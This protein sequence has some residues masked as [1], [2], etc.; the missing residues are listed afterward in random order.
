[1]KREIR[2]SSTRKELNLH[3]SSH[4]YT[5][6]W[7]CPSVRP[8]WRTRVCQCPSSTSRISPFYACPVML[9][10]GRSTWGVLWTL[11]G[12][13]T[14]KHSVKEQQ[15]Y[16]YLCASGRFCLCRS[17]QKEQIVPWVWPKWRGY[18]HCLCPFPS[19]SALGTTWVLGLGGCAAY[20][21]P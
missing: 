11:M 9:Y 7:Q 8:M 21:P 1:M 13:F 17:E 20:W 4:I 10:L 19:A 14:G 12:D 15:T 16:R 3:L 5:I 6:S 18:G 2:L